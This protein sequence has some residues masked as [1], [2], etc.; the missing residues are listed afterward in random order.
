MC[1][2]DRNGGEG[3]GGHGDAR[4]ERRA[5]EEAGREEEGGGGP[6]ERLE[7]R[8][9]EEGGRRRRGFEDGGAARS[10]KP[11]Y[12]VVADKP[13]RCIYHESHPRTRVRRTCGGLASLV[14]PQDVGPCF[15]RNF[16][17]RRPNL[18]KNQPGLPNHNP[19]PTPAWL[20]GWVR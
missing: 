13:A 8:G 12:V 1:V 20:G 19:K 11:E 10:S 9:G 5:R 7:W 15:R 16:I 3:G 6:R 18:G 4:R 2:G 17:P 14:T